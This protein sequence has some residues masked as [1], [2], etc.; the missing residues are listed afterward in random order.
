MRTLYLILLIHLCIFASGA[1]EWR[2][3]RGTSHDA[4]GKGEIYPLEW[5]ETQNIVWKTAIHDEGWSSPVILDDQIWL[6]SASKDG[7]QLYALAVDDRTGEILHD[8]KVFEPASPQR[9]HSLNTYATPT[10]A[11]EPGYAYVHFGTEGTACLDTQSGEVLWKRTDLNCEHV[12]GAASSPIIYKNLLIV[13]LEGTDVQFITALDK[14]TGKTVWQ[15]ERPQQYYVDVRPI[16]RKAYITPIV[17]SV[18]DR[19]LLI[20]NGAQVCEA[21]DANTG[22]PVWLVVYGTDSTVSVPLWFNGLAII[23]TGLDFVRGKNQSQLWAVKPNGQGDVTESHVAWKALEHVPG[24]STPVIYEDLLYMV[25]EKGTAT[26]LSP[27]DGKRVW[28]KELDG[29]Y[30]ASP[31]AAAGHVYFTNDR[32][33]TTVLKAGQTFSKIAQNELNEKILATPALVNG[34]IIMRTA[35]FLYKISK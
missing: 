26:C 25:D 13:H 5:S 12:Q 4:V 18:N 3:F 30:H 15:H 1:A 32:G 9:K 14:K 6:T 20:S 27:Q 24:L 33:V 16:W 34:E 23:N 10:P 19:D 22:E 2:E 21:L 28:Q 17:V 29:N 35:G 8:L 7:K 31:V 11:L